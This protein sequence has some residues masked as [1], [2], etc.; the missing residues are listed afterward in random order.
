MALNDKQKA[1]VA[2]YL[3]D[4]NATESTIRARYSGENAKSQ[5]QRMLPNVDI[6][7]VIAEAQ[8]ERSERAQIGADYVS[9]LHPGHRCISGT[10]EVCDRTKGGPE[11]PPDGCCYSKRVRLSPVL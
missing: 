1:Y 5:G 10:R 4:L 7:S 2:E 8:Q 9:R 11:G 6:E 3:I